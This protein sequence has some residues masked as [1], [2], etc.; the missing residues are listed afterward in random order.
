[1]VIPLR[2]TIEFK[3]ASTG[4]CHLDWTQTFPLVTVTFLVIAV[5]FK[6][7]NNS[8]K[9]QS[10]QVN[11]AKMTVQAF[12]CLFLSCDQ[13]SLG[14]N[15]IKFNKKTRVIWLMV[16]VGERVRQ[17]DKTI[18]R[19][20]EKVWGSF[21]QLIISFFKLR[22]AAVGNATGRVASSTARVYDLP[23]P[24][25]VSWIM[26][27]PNHTVHVWFG[28]VSDTTNDHIL[29]TTRQKYHSIS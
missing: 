11:I 7:R 19:C 15:K 14:S 17:V 1:M 6:I 2:Y 21:E 28:F 22:F 29:S 5:V 9:V 24:V 27:L 4:N 20:K 25:Y 26:I 13:I 23:D 3:T 18:E 10:K 8:T 12:S 16:N